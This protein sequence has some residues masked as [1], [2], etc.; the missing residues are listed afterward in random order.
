M[1]IYEY[2]CDACEHHL[3]ALQGL[4]DPPLTDC[5]DCNAA[6]LRKL[7]SAPAFHL[8]GTGWYATD[9]RDKSTE[10]AAKT[11]NEDKKLSQKA[12]TALS[13]LSV[14]LTGD[15]YATKET[16]SHTLGSPRSVMG[17]H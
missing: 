2:R 3:E 14:N 8:K 9:F 6:A 11:N 5:P 16:N 12:K 10:K 7:V 15:G 13:L 4:N 17:T 1:P